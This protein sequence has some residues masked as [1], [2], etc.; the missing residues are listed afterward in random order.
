MLLEHSWHIF[1]NLTMGHRK[2][3]ALALELLKTEQA[4]KILKQAVRSL[5]PQIRLACHKAKERKR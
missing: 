5:N 4:A 1:G 3:A 2:G